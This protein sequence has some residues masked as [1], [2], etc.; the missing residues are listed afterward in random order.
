[1]GPAGEGRSA[2]FRAPFHDGG[3]AIGFGI[4]P[5]GLDANLRQG[6][7]QFHMQKPVIEP[8]T[9]N[10][11]AFRQHKGALELASGDAAMQENP[12]FRIILLPA[13]DD[14]LIVFLLDLQI[15]HGEPGHRQRDAQ[16]V[17]ADLF[18]VVGRVALGI[19]AISLGY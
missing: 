3:G 6:P 13:P 9:F 14:Q 15:I 16:P 17:I 10:L 2:P 18:D 12:A 19:L 1:M 8:G 7:L 5:D 11:Y 4:N